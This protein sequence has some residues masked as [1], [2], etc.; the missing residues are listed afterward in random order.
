[1]SQMNIT[2][3]KGYRITMKTHGKFSPLFLNTA[4]RRGT[5]GLAHQLDVFLYYDS[6]YDKIICIL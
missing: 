5:S 3:G 1:M 4:E 2:I 6:S